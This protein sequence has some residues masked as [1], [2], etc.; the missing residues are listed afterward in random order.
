MKIEVS[1][2]TEGRATVK[3]T[4]NGLEKIFLIN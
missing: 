4:Y 2:I 1:P 3:C